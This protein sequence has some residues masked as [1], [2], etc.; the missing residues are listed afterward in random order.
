VA[1]WNGDTIMMAQTPSVLPAS[2]LPM[3]P[4]V[5]L[6]D[7]IA[8]KW[9][10]TG[11]AVKSLFARPKQLPNAKTSPAVSPPKS[12]AT[13]PL[14][15]SLRGSITPEVNRG[16]PSAQTPL[17]LKA[18][19]LAQNGFISSQKNI[20]LFK[21]NESTMGATRKWLNNQAQNPVALMALIILSIVLIVGILLPKADN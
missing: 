12:T 18:K 20:A 8:A 9:N 13:K 2:Y 21:G 7:T 3:A 4:K 19:T 15:S 17:I 5:T 6:G 11:R 10:G 14:T 16:Q 1:S